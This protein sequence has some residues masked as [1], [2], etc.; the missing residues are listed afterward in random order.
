MDLFPGPALGV[1]HGLEATPEK[2][3]FG[4]PCGDLAMNERT[5]DVEN[6]TYTSAP[7]RSRLQHDYGALGPWN[8]MLPAIGILINE[9]WER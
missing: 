4:N 1:F 6:F 5:A 7:S 8:L 2:I 9:T 3:N